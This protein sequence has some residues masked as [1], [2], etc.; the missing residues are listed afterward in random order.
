MSKN[1]FQKWFR[2]S[3]TRNIPVRHAVSPALTLQVAT[4]LMLH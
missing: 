1:G 4:N 2:I 3:V